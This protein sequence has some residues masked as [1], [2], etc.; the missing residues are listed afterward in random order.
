MQDQYVGDVGDFVKYGL[1]RAISEG[2]H[3]GVAWYLRADRGTS[4]LQQPEKWRCR[5]RPTAA[6]EEISSD[7]ASDGDGVRPQHE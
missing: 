6:P 4:Y 3:L 1:L 5:D 7:G 2:K